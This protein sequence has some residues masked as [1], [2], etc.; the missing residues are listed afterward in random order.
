LS[1]FFGLS[2]HLSMTDS[3]EQMDEQQIIRLLKSDDRK[4]Q[5]K[6]FTMLIR[7]KKDL[8][9]KQKT[10]HLN[11]A[12]LDDI[13]Y[14]SLCVLHK[15]INDFEYRGS[16]SLR[17]YLY[18]IIKGKISNEIK[19]KRL[20]ELTGDKIDPKHSL[21][22]LFSEEALKRVKEILD[23]KVG[24]DCRKIIVNRHYWGMKLDEIAEQ[25]GLALGTVRNKS[26]NCIKSMQNIANGDTQLKKVILDLFNM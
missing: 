16:G 20:I 12:D 24:E 23:K 6:G 4:A 14:T 22:S 18:G 7:W 3:T 26:A 11:H 15:K 13:F 25:M 2:R 9:K 8:L 5:N 21:T 1:D 17:A 10:F 19:K